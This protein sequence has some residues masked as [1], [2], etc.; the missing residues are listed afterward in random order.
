MVV[1]LPPGGISG[2]PYGTILGR[3]VIPTEFNATCG[4]VGDIVFANLDNYLTISKGGVQE[5]ASPHV[6]SFVIKSP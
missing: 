4:T 5:T 6:E 3:P 1:Y 2:A